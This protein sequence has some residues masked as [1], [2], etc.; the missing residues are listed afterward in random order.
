MCLFLS[1]RLQHQ[2]FEE[3]QEAMKK[4]LLQLSLLLRALDPELCD[5]LGKS[6]NVNTA[7]PIKQTLHIQY[8]L[9]KTLWR[10]VV[11]SEWS[12][13]AVLQMSFE[14]NRSILRTFLNEVLYLSSCITI[15][16]CILVRPSDSQDSG[17]LCFCFRWLLIWFKREFSFE[18]ILILWEVSTVLTFYVFNNCF[19]GFRR[20]VAHVRCCS[21][22]PTVWECAKSVDISGTGIEEINA[23]DVLQ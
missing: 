12:Q 5:F 1:S 15:S 4:Q 9:K 18:D 17:S 11:H 2:N 14:Y 19:L 8:K 10:N 3:S 22:R 7:F 20:A 16:L 23:F 13:W 6:F 21:C